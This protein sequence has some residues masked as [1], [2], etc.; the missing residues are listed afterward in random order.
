[1]TETRTK[2]TPIIADA[3]I[4]LGYGPLILDGIDPKSLLEFIRKNCFNN[5]AVPN[6]I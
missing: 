6:K 5:R 1:M 3:L 2:L 4:E